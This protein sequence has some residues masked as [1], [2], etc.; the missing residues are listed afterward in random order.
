M[1]YITHKWGKVQ[2]Q[3]LCGICMSEVPSLLLRKRAITSSLS[4][5][6]FCHLQISGEL[7]AIL[8]SLKRKEK[9]NKGWSYELTQQITKGYSLCGVHSGL[10][11][12][13]SLGDLFLLFSSLL[14]LP[15]LV[16]L[17]PR[18]SLG[19]FLYHYLYIFLSRLDIHQGWWKTCWGV[20]VHG[21]ESSASF[22]LLGDE[23]LAEE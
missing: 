18:V 13:T 17:L 6:L 8:E 2:L 12:Q 21:E 3:K 14:S 10:L 15:F 7:L 1:T 23:K 22:D 5:N 16:R 20:N 9:T 4:Q 19:L 11:P